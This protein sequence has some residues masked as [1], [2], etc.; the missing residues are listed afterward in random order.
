MARLQGHAVKPATKAVY[1]PLIDMKPSDPD[2]TLTAMVE[3]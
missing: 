1:T 3:A 2:T